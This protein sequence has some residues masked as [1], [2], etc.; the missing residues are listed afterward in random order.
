MPAPEKIGGASRSWNARMGGL[1]AGCPRMM[2]TRNLVI[3]HH[4]L[5]NALQLE[6]TYDPPGNTWF[7]VFLGAAIIAGVAVGVLLG[8]STVVIGAVGGGMVAGIYTL[9]QSWRKRKATLDVMHAPMLFLTGSTGAWLS[10]CQSKMESTGLSLN[11]LGTSR[12]RRRML[13]AS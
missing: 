13:L 6:A 1:C 12:R 10:S 11:L 3:L 9:V 8:I 7:I 2:G 4:N 5:G